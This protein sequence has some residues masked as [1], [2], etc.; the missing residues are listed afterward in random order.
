MEYDSIIL[1]LM[2]RIKVLEARCSE[3]G[4]QVATITAQ[5][6]RLG[7]TDA[8][9]SSTADP[10]EPLV[11]KSITPEIIR[12]TYEC[13]VLLHR[14]GSRGFVDAIDALVAETGMNRNSAI[15]YAYAAK[16]ML[17]GEPYK[18]A[19][20]ALATEKFFLYILDDFGLEA[21][22]NAIRATRAHIEIRHAQGHVVPGLIALCDKYDAR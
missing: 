1:E 12:A 20:S 18:R 2:T 16:Y 22:K 21:Q 6:L 5:Q 3:L 10:R 9:G 19:I 17:S 13:G 7:E 14:N 8:G 4:E 15:M 11:R